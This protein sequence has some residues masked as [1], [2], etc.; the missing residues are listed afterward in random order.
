[1]MSILTIL[2]S[3]RERLRKACLV[4]CISV[5]ATPAWG[6]P[7]EKP[8]P[9]DSPSCAASEN[10]LLDS[11][12]SRSGEFA[13][14]W[15]VGQHAGETAFSV[16]SED[17]VLEIRRIGP[18][19]WMLFSQNVTDSRLAGATLRYT[20]QLKGDLPTEPPLHG[21][22]HVA[23]LYL[24]AGRT[25]S[26]LADHQPNSGLWDWQSISAEFVI[27]EGVTSLKVGFF[28]QAGGSL[29]ARSP[30]LVLLDCDKP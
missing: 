7:N 15:R 2:C 19:P 23:G 5:L 16:E 10:L 12:F 20:A 8:A 11:D 17:G 25:V 6:E 18:Q 9:D 4:A 1:M 29:W 26:Y 27:P 30:S 21:F 13:G 22:D 14:V 3:C 28:H 24:R